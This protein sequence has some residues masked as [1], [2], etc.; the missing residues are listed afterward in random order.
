MIQFISLDTIIN[1]LLNTIRGAKVSQ[2]E[3]ISKRQIEDWIHQYRATLIKQDLDKGKIPNPDYIQEIPS[4]RLEVVDQTTGS[5]FES[6]TYLLRTV[7]ELPETID[8]NFKPGFMYVGTIDGHEIQF[9][10][11]SRTKWQK[12]KRFTKYVPLAFL[13]NKRIHLSTVAP[14]QYITVRGIFEI[15]TEVSNF[16]NTSSDVVYST[17][18]DRY[19]VPANWVPIIKEMILSKELGI[20]TTTPSDT[21][22][23]GNNKVSVNAQE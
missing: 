10:P 20:I 4:L 5:V 2:S 6:D 21:T 15:P 14:I 23:D 18:R 13:R 11:E 9:G 7:L 22:N 3:Q 19:P 12:F 16:I 8:L 17:Y 1:D